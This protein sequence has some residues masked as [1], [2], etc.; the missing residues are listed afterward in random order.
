MEITTQVQRVHT[1][2]LTDEDVRLLIEHPMEFSVEF[3]AL[4]DHKLAPDG[5]KKSRGKKAV[6]KGGR[7]GRATKAEQ[8]HCFECDRDFASQRALRLHRTR[9][10]SENF[11]TTGS[12]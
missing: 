11:I 1:L 7:R 2:T 12:D 5:P 8:F 3:E 6:K 9:K 4:L 10:H